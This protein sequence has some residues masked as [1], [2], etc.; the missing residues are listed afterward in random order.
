LANGAWP[1]AKEK[2]FRRV[3]KALEAIFDRF[4][5]HLVRPTFVIQ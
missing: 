1:S 5:R 4:R 2:R 3:I